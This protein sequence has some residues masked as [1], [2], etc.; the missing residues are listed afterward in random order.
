M[1]D[2]EWIVVSFSWMHLLILVV[3]VAAAVGVLAL[4]WRSWR[5]KG[6]DA[7]ISLTLTLS[8]FCA[9][10]GVL[11]AIAAVVGA[12]ANTQ[13]EMTVPVSTYWPVLPDGVTVS[14]TTATVGGGGFTQA[15]VWVEGASTGAR[16]LWGIGQALGGLVPAAIA[17]LIALVCFQLLRG[18]AFAPVVARAAMITAVVVLVGGMSADVL[19]GIGGSMVSHEL[20]AWTSASGTSDPAADPLLNWPQATFS[21]NFPL[22]PIGAGL[23]FAALAAV[24]RYGGRLQR[25]TE[26]LV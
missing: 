12:L 19:C 10:I 9:A 1:I 5:R 4:A 6:T 23:G 11:G 2:M 21:A 16:V 26:G 25:D 8:A 15:D 24:F 13:V 3:L 20:L 22:W 14:G 7:V 18:A 17:G